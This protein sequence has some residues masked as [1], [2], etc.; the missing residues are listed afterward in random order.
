MLFEF[1]WP[2]YLHKKVFMINFIVHICID[3]SWYVIDLVHDFNA[4]I[5][6]YVTDVTDFLNA[7][8]EYSS[9][10]YCKS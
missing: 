6:I 7:A 2:K 9:R 5:T 10:K 3:I 8:H 4:A 1:K